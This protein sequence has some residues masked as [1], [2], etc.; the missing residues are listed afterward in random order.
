[1]PLLRHDRVVGWGNISIVDGALQSSFGYRGFR[2]S[3]DASF[4]AALAAELDR[5][6]AF[7]GLQR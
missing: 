1:M 7:L 2:H 3:T 6:R 4:D 5:M